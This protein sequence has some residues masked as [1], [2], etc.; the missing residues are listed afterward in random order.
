[1]ANPTEVICPADE[2]TKVASSVKTGFVHVVKSE[3]VAL[4]Q[5]Y[6]TAGD[7][8]PTNLDLPVMLIQPTDDINLTANSD[9]YV[10]SKG[11]ETILRVDV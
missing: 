2:W 10:Y 4:Y 11:G 1:M 8:A 6:R 7:K 3:M 5:T 9:I